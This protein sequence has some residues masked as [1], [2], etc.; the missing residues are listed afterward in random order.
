MP[1]NTSIREIAPAIAES[2]LAASY[3]PTDGH[4][5]PIATVQAFAD[6]A[7]RNGAMLCTETTVTAIDASGGR[8]RGVHAT[9]GDVAADAVVVAAGV[10]TTRLCA[11]LGVDVPIQ[12]RHVA[13]VQTVPLPPLIQQVLGTA[14]ADFAGRQEVGGRFRLT[15]GGS[16]GRTISTTSRR[17]RCRAPAFRHVIDALQR[18]I[19]VLPA[20]AEARVARVWGGLIDATPDALPVIERA[21]GVDGLVVAAGFSGHGF[22]LG[23]VTGQIVRDLV[24]EGRPRSRSSRSGATVSLASRLTQRQRSTDSDVVTNRGAERIPSTLPVLITACS[25]RW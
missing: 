22:C 12:V 19:E 5:N 8:V 11:P 18:G 25:P 14:G 21:P 4:A 6:A 20:L 2:V 13:V 3:C 7:E 9:S 1:D 10:Y 23:P 24:L 16:P 15:G 17:Q